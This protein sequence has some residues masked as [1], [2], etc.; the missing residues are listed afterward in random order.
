MSSADVERVFNQYKCIFRDNRRGFSFENLKNTLFWNVNQIPLTRKIQEK[1]NKCA[2]KNINEHVMCKYV[3]FRSI[4][5]GIVNLVKEWP[6]E[7]RDRDRWNEFAVTDGYLRLSDLRF[8]W[9]LNIILLFS[10]SNNLNRKKIIDSPFSI[11]AVEQT[12][13]WLAVDLRMR[14]WA[15]D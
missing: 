12:Q 10:P 5:R 13:G 2:N 9:P 6:N 15:T 7:F 1:T 3:C 14:T 11:V 4:L 8:T